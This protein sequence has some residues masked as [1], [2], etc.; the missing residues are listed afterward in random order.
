MTS[1]L[2]NGALATVFGGSGFIGRHAVR[3][4]AQRGARIRAATRRPDLAGYLQPMGRVGQI[5]PVQANLRFE[6]SIRRALDGAVVAVNLVGILV[7]S[8][9][10]SFEALHVAGARAVARAAREAGVRHLVHVSAIGADRAAPS[11]Y[12]RTKAEGEAAVLA[13]FPE[14]VIVRPSI[15]FGPEDQF[16]NRFAAMARVAPF[17]PLIGG[18]RTK[19]QPVYVGNVATAIAEA[20]EGNAKPGTVYELGGPET[21]S[22]RK[23]LDRTQEWAGRDK[24][25]LP[26]PFWLAKLG[27]ALTAPL[28][29]GLRPLTVDQV[30]SLQQDCVV[31]EAA[32]N[33][34]RVLQ[35]LGVLHPHAI[36]TIVPSYLEQYRT[37][38]QYSHY[39]G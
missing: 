28:P 27:G 16:F 32:R 38:G 9:R 3:A 13:E 36:G 25:Y 2:S 31:S 14:A 6:D 15:V 23:L 33:E 18:G 20:A 7:P 34:G 19:F 22:F 5:M 4:L 1:P 37:K 29:A 10:Q 8:G 12:G 39:R 26:L 21:Y 17:L 11:V 24:P 30:R 35:D